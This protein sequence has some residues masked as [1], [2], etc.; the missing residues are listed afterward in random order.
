MNDP[1]FRAG[2][3]S[4]NP[5][6]S[7]PRSRAHDRESRRN[8]WGATKPLGVSPL[9]TDAQRERRSLW[10]A[11]PSEKTSYGDPA[12]SFSQRKHREVWEN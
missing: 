1:I 2:S 8:M 7:P 11:K 10:E 4:D 9:W 5:I 6:I 3:T 12:E